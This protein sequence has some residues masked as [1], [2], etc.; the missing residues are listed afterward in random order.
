MLIK[1]FL[2][3]IL[4]LSVSCFADSG[5]DKSKSSTDSKQQTQSSQSSSS[6]SDSSAKKG[7]SPSTQDSNTDKKPSMVD[8]CKKHTC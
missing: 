2:A 7:S 3:A 8:Y 4:S 1:F 6:T 5:A